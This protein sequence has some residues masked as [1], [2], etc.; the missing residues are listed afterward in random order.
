M[1]KKCLIILSISFAIFA[2]VSI[3]AGIFVE[4]ATKSITE[5]DFSAQHGE[6]ESIEQVCFSDIVENSE[7]HTAKPMALCLVSLPEIEKSMG[8]FSYKSRDK[9][10]P[11]MPPRPLTLS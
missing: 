3:Q 7:L 4:K 1:L 9:D 11:I 10:R 2:P 5:V 6:I 8:I